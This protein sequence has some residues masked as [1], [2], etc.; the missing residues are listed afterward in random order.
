MEEITTEEVIEQLEIEEEVQSIEELTEEV[1]TE[2]E[3]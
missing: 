2:V 1:E 3:E